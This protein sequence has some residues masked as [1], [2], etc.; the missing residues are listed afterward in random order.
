[1]G[2]TDD[3]ALRIAIA[4]GIV[5]GA[6]ARELSE[7]AARTGQGVL[8]RLRAEGRISGPTFASLH[9]RMDEEPLEQSDAPIESPSSAGARSNASRCGESLE[10]PVR[11]TAPT[12]TAEPTL[13]PAADPARPGSSDQPTLRKLGDADTW[14][15]DPARDVRA[16][17]SV[18][19][20]AFPVPGWDR[21]EPIRLLGQGGMGRVFL[22]KDLRLVR[23][24]AIKFVRGDDPEYARR[25]VAEARAQARVNDERVCKVYEVGEVRGR[26]YIAMQH[27]DGKPLSELADELTLE[28]K[29]LVV[30]GAALGIAEAHRVGLIHRDVKPSNIMVE[31]SSDGE[32]RP[33]VMDFGLA[34]DWTDGTTMTGTVLGTPQYMAPE[35]AAGEVKQLDRRAD[36][37]SLGATLY[38]LLVGEP[39]VAGSNALEILTRV[40]SA[41]PTRPRMIDPDVPAD[42]EA[43][44]MKCLEKERAARYDSARALADDLG[45]FLAGEPVAARATAGLGY[46]LRKWIRRRARLVVGVAAAVALVAVAL[47]F[48][49]HERWQAG[50]RAEL[51]RRFTERVERIEASA[52]YAALA[53]SHDIRPDRARLRAAMDELAAEV[54][55]AGDL[56]AGPGRYALGRGYLALGD[57]ERAAAELS[58]AWAQGYRA[59]RAAYALALAEGHL[60][61]QA[62]HEAERLPKDLREERRGAIAH[63]YREPALAHLR[64][65]EGAEVPSVDYVAALVAYYEERFDDALR[66][67]DAIDSGPTGLAWFYEA[68]LL[69]GEILRARAMAHRGTATP[70]QITADLDAGRRALATAATVG[71]SDPAVYRAQGEL[72]ASTLDLEIYGGGAIEA[73]FERGVEAAGRAL[74][75]LPDDL[76]ALELRCGLL[77]RVAEYRGNRG[78]DVTA[79]L[80]REIADASRILE[81]APARREGK[82]ELARAYRHWGQVRNARTEDPTE[83][84]RKAAEVMG[85]IAP[86]D[87][88]YDVQVQL[89][90]IYNIWADYQEQTGQDSERYRSMAIDAY[91][92]AIRINGQRASA[93]LNLGIN[94]YARGSQPRSREAEAEL[95]RAFE[96]LEKGRELD[97]RSFMP[98]FYEGEVFA[99][100][101]QRKQARGAPPDPDRARAI[102]SY[103]QGLVINPKLPHLHNGIANVQ[104]EQAKE[105][106]EQGRDP[107][108]FLDQA[109]SAAARAIAVAPEQGHGYNNL[110]EALA[111]RAAYERAHGRDPRPIAREAAS[112]FA[113]ALE[114]MPAY[115]LFLLNLAS[116][117]LL[118]A[119]YELDHGH[120]PWEHLALARRSIDRALARDPTSEQAKRLLAEAQDLEA[121]WRARSA[122]RQ[123]GASGGPVSPAPR[124]GAAP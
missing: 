114:R 85:T 12:Q 115:P 19:P 4:E 33:Y 72:E 86:E 69:R 28:Q 92:N 124:E 34:R 32:L 87:R 73:P 70:A 45:R 40:I 5:S 24:V 104:L 42:L 105:A 88:D 93:W 84:L 57:D 118:I 53:P 94:Y 26:V 58:A 11:G 17:G 100:L 50:R 117:Q 102:E 106:S 120:D 36:V 61:Q 123:A 54:R 81:L 7:E 91:A 10:E 9:A 110:G 83:Q 48:A 60:Y 108:P 3:L 35:Q 46:R 121:R 71:R 18:D 76:A 21:Y 20:N 89:G 75:V 43:I 97:P 30:R 119:G 8:E 65:S 107:T 112:S 41:E 6:E 79:L 101:A 80:R 66:R 90:L 2:A 62:L 15:Y 31:R 51:A 55:A 67:L 98:Y 39:P 52:R 27:I 59:P 109:Q 103:R 16:S 47:G 95:G 14:N 13:G 122:R 1:M 63:R 116:I 37:Y 22:A 113:R 23:N 82:L 99:Q 111:Q 38:C 64:E 25:I 56:G 44:A 96:A 49:L 77:R 78:E 74:A 68:P 29:A